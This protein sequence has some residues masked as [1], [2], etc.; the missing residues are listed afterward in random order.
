MSLND[1]S[2]S[3]PKIR[4][5][6]VN[7]TIHNLFIFKKSG[8]CIYGKNFTNA[9]K[10]E[11]NLIS[12]FFTAIR[13]FSK[14]VVGKKVKLIEMGNLKFVILIK[15]E[16]F[17]GYLSESNES[18]LILENITNKIH[19]K[20]TEQINKHLVNSKNEYV[21]DLEFDKIIDV[22]IEEILS[23]E[24]DLDIESKIIEELEEFSKNQDIKGIVLLTNKGRVI[25]SSLRS[26]ELRNLLK[27]VDFRVKIYNNTILKMYYTSKN[28]NLIFSEY[29]NDMYFIVLVFDFNIKFGM[30][31]Y[32]LNKIVDFIKLVLNE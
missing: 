7:M 29:V 27:E 16:Y 3:S 22:I 6:P 18:L 8:I 20:F 23:T 30:A 4:R 13:S 25:Y 10:L 15:G 11:D 9:Y 12:A 31:E 19:D 14:E 17:Y 28:G 5:F 21:R 1:H 26:I 24:Y 32:Y 2:I